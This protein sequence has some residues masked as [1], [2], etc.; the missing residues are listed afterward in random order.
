[1]NIKQLLAKSRWLLVIGIIALSVIIV[2]ALFATKPEASRRGPELAPPLR[3]EVQQIQP[4]DYEVSVA[5]YGT[6]QPKTQSF[7]VAQVGGMVVSVS[8]NFR[9]GAFIKKGDLLL[10]IDER[11]FDIEVNVA[12]ANLAD[13]KQAY[14]QELAQ[15][16][17]ALKDWQSLGLKGDPNDLVLRKPQLESARSNLLAAESSLDRA[18]INLERTK[19]VAPFDGRLINSF[20]DVGQVVASNTQLGEIYATDYVEVRLPLKNS[21]LGFVDLPENYVDSKELTGNY[22][23]VVLTSGFGNGDTWI[24]EIVRVE[25]VIDTSARQLH[26][27]AQ[28]D[29]PFSTDHTSPIKIGQYVTAEISGTTMNDAVVIPNTAIYQN[30]FVY[31][32]EEGVVQRR[33]IDIAWQSSTDTVISSGIEY[34]DRLVVTPL[35]QVTSGTRIEIIDKAADKDS[36]SSQSQPDPTRVN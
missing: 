30:S 17:Q 33:D 29:N 11:D 36:V 10:Q 23:D 9:D 27:I 3:V 12:K 5:S 1:M 26:V 20:V 25:S 18:E 4:V 16:E 14:A 13:A 21:D 34:G 7:L 35:G 6:V 15:S 31:I 24:G 22:P 28:I 2:S 8:E 19:I 32:A